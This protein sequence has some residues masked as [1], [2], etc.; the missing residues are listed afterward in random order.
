VDQLAKSGWNYLYFGEGKDLPTPRY[1]Y[2][3]MKGS[4]AGACKINEIEFQ[5]VE[6]IDDN[7]PTYQCTPKLFINGTDSGI[8]LNP[9]TY[10]GT[11]TPKLTAI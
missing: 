3:R 11:L 5:G 8:S 4:V 7:N 2:Y 9:V 6:T 10:S 1:R